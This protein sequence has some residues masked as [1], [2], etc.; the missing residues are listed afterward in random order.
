MSL[1][2]LRRT[3]KK[4]TNEDKKDEDWMVK[5]ANGLR[6]VKSMALTAPKPAA[7]GSAAPLLPFSRYFDPYNMVVEDD[8]FPNEVACFIEVAKESRNKYEWDHDL[9]AMRL[10]RVLHS[11]VYYPHDYGFIP[12]TLCGDGDPLD[13]LVMTTS[14]LIPGCVV[15]ARP[16]AVMIMEDEKGQDEK[17]LAVNA[18]DAHFGQIKSMKDVP[19]HTLREISEFFSTYKRLEK[20]KWAKVQGWKGLEECLE[21]IKKTHENYKSKMEAAV[22]A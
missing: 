13:I 8:K 17:V 20:D 6:N 11:A 7:G 2:G 10:D 22:N 9:G 3:N 4:K 14:P 1:F 16:V 12:Q 5:T 18:K 15:Q 19:E 21:L